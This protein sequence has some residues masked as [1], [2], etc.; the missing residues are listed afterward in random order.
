MNRSITIIRETRSSRDL[1]MVE[2]APISRLSLLLETKDGESEVKKS[3]LSKITDSSLVDAGLDILS[4]IGVSLESGGLAASLTGVGAVA[5]VP[6]GTVGAATSLV[7]DLINALRHALR[8]DYYSAILYLL[9]AIPGAGDILQGVSWLSKG[10]KAG[11]K[12]VVEIYPKLRSLAKA[13]RLKNLATSAY[14]LLEMGLEKIPGL[15]KHREPLRKTLDAVVE[16][17]PDKIVAVAKEQGHEITK[18]ELE[19]AAERKSG[20]SASR[21]SGDSA[22]RERISESS[23]RNAARSRRLVDLYKGVLY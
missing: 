10:A 22:D 17:D 4:G 15:K 19:A 9:F 1:L 21:K 23:I 13:N 3:L 12:G 20:E 7:A 14:E 16:G 2:N 18:A 6:I 5:G 11:I 8:G